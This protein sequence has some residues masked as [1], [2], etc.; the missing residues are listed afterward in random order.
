MLVIKHLS[1]PLAGQEIRVDPTL[2][3]VVFGRNL[4]CQV[5][6]PPEDVIIS[7]EH[8]AFT[9]KPPGPAGHWSVDLFGEPYVAI[10]GVPAE[11][12]EAV[13]DGQTFE[14]GKKSGPSFRVHLEADASSDNK[15]RTARQQRRPNVFAVSSLAR[16]IAILGA[17][18]TVLV[19]AAGTYYYLKVAGLIIPAEVR[20]HLS[21]ATFL[22][23]APE[24]GA[25]AV[26]L[27][28]D[29]FGPDTPN[30]VLAT[31]AHVAAMFEDL[32]P[33]EEMLVRGPGVNGATYRVIKH[34]IHPGYAAFQ[35]FLNQD[36]LR[37][38]AAQFDEVGGYDVALLWVDKDLKDDKG[39]PIAGFDLASPDELKALGPGTVVATAG[40]PM[41]GVVGSG[42]QIFGASP[43]Y[44]DGAIT[45]LTDFFFETADYANAQLIHHNLAAAGG[46]SGSPIV[47]RSG[48]LVALLSAGNVYQPN[49]NGP[50]IPSGVMINYGQRIDLL[51]H[52]IA[53]DADK[54]VQQDMDYWNKQIRNFAGGPAIAV[55]LE[56]QEI[57]EENNN[58]KIVLDSVSQQT[59]TLKNRVKKQD[60]FQR[61]FEYKIAVTPGTKYLFM[62]Y[63]FDGSPIEVWVYDGTQ[64]VAKDE[65]QNFLATVPYQATN[66]DTLDIWVIA[67]EDRDVRYSFMAEKLEVPG[68]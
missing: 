66:K 26:V 7:R 21:D 49:K 25:T 44:H 1:G 14:L 50:R 20:E 27:N 4:D 56:T 28:P 43:E 67:P 32:K 62:A 15:Q 31:N 5:V 35:N 9:R 8:F 12:G 24:G 29:I 63:A 64:L 54:E 30:R 59:S 17:T 52:L 53:G 10:N 65:K 2:D 58:D 37:T 41:E 19:G 42:S 68:T 46:S 51:Q 18:L 33:G 11:Q 57:Q 36:V 22:V 34:E 45:S 61:Q 48:H 39:Q 40:Y 55:K 6:Y 23:E 38:R 16:R 13:K 60:A 3:R 47:G